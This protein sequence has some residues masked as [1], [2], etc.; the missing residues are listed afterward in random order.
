MSEK[1]KPVNGTMIAWIIVGLIAFNILA[2]FLYWKSILIKTRSFFI[3]EGILV[4]ISAFVALLIIIVK[5]IE[6]AN[7]EK[8]KKIKKLTVAE[9]IKFMQQYAVGQYN[10][11]VKVPYMEDIIRVG[12]ESQ[13]VDVFFAFF[14]E[15]D[16]NKKVLFYM[17]LDNPVNVLHRIDSNFIEKLERIH[18]T[19][20]FRQTLGGMAEDFAP[21][22]KSRTK[23]QYI[24]PNG[25]MIDLS[26]V[27]KKKEELPKQDAM[28]KDIGGGEKHGTTG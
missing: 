16:N 24:S 21:I 3:I 11:K 2:W 15:H 1:N 6:N 19:V 9:A 12:E 8:K 13:Q 25:Q 5:A 22:K 28:A 17:C 7:D 18:G 27:D 14:K 4:G 10:I 20:I 23:V 26:G